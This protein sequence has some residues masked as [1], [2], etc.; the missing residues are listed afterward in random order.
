MRTGV[1]AGEMP[2][3]TVDLGRKVIAQRI[4]VGEREVAPRHARL[5]RHDHELDPDS[6]QT[7]H[8]LAGAGREADPG[9]VDVVGQ[10]LDEGPVLVEEQDVPCAHGQDVSRIGRTVISGITDSGGSDSTNRMVSATVRGSWRSVGS[11]SGNR[12]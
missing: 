1:E 11:S 9:G 4:E 3:E 7:A 8:G 6:G 10:V 2:T 5:V 12:S